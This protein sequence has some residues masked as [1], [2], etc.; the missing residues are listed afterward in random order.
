MFKSRQVLSGATIG[1]VLLTLNIMP[2]SARDSEFRQQVI[3][4][5]HLR[6]QESQIPAINKR[7]ANFHHIIAGDEPAFI[8]PPIIVG[9]WPYPIPASSTKHTNRRF[10]NRLA[11]KVTRSSIFSPQDLANWQSSGSGTSR[12]LELD[13]TSGNTDIVLGS[14]LFK[15]AQTVKI[16]VG[17]ED[18]EFGPGSRVTP[19]EYVAIKIVLS[20][21]DQTLTLDAQGTATGGTF[22]L[23][24]VLNP[25]V[26]SLVVPEGVTGFDYFSSNHALGV[27]GD[28]INYG[29]IYGVSTD[30]RVRSGILFARDLTNQASGI[31]STV[32]PESIAT[33]I[34]NEVSDV[35]LSLVAY[36]NL[37][38]QGTIS[39]S[40]SLTLATATGDI[41]NTHSGTWVT[42]PIYDEP[43]M[44]Y[45]AIVWLQP[46]PAPGLSAAQDINLV[47]G[48]GTV[49]NSGSITST[50]GNVNF[51]SNLPNTNVNVYSD[52]GTIS[53][54]NGAINV[55]NPLYTG[56]NS[57]NMWGGDYFAKSLSIYSG[58]GSINGSIGHAPESITTVGDSTYFYTNQPQIFLTPKNDPF[59]PTPVPVNTLN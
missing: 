54:L 9:P 39:S 52:W 29:S 42:P 58:T 27:R 55:R 49:T 53:A 19:G 57:A 18:R 10:L 22:E 7:T 20:G 26:C 25:H 11:D 13:L 47:A 37:T 31:I 46:G 40:G 1:V 14:K 6:R 50:N 15:E 17:G 16:V 4:N 24:G 36:N 2:S 51:S 35:S 8:G 59:D 38:N 45:P 48:S 21:Q 32:L 44:F 3:N 33:S 28:L 56:T 12:R 41:A 34:N 5:R 30:E 23:N 43:G